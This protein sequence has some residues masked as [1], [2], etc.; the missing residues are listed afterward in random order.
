MLRLVDVAEE[1]EDKAVIFDIETEEVVVVDP[2]AQAVADGIYEGIELTRKAIDLDMSNV[3]VEALQGNTA[4]EYDPVA[5]R[6]IVDLAAMTSAN[7]EQIADILTHEGKHQENDTQGDHQLVTNV[8]LN[9]DLTE[10]DAAEA[11][12]HDPI[13]YPEY[14]GTIEAVAQGAN[15]TRENLFRLYRAGQNAEINALFAE[16]ANDD[17]QLAAAA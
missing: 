15:T 4:G 10:T 6:I 1:Y 11:R 13:A 16:A 14:R 17:E 3:E 12:G 5:N 7:A 8:A 2:E 9:E